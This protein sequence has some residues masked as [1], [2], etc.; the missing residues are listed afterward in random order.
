[1]LNA[2]VLVGLK[3]AVFTCR[4]AN[5]YSYFRRRYTTTLFAHFQIIVYTQL[6]LDELLYVYFYIYS[7]VGIYALRRCLC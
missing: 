5:E 3:S 7:Q 6:N 2:D 1:M 4:P